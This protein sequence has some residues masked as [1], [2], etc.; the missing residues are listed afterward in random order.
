VLKE[1]KYDTDILMIADEMVEQAAEKV[2]DIVDDN[3]C[4]GRTH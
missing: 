2:N 3:I 4:N 1:E